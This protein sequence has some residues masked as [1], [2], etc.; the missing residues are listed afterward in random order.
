M[1][2]EK[3]SEM[4]STLATVLQ[5]NLWEREGWCQLK[6]DIAS[7]AHSLVQYVEYL[8]EKNDSVKRYHASPT[9]ARELSDNLRLK[10]IPKAAKPYV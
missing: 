4:A 2:R 9:P 10:A 1:S 8:S 3:L 5:A 7:L 6:L